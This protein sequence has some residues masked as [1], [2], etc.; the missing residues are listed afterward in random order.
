M[1]RGVVYLLLVL[2]V[3]LAV[4]WFAGPRVSMDATVTFDPATIGS[5]PDAYLAAAES[6]V[7]GIE[8]GLRKEI[9]WAHPA[10]K[11]R[12][13]LAIVYIHGFSA[14]K[15]ELRPLPDI[16]ARELGAN[17]FYTRLAGHGQDSAAM[18]TAS[19]K[20]WAD[21]FAEAMAIGRAIGERV[22][23]MATSTG[24]GLATWGAA[25]RP[26]LME[27]VEALVLF[28]P[29]FGAQAFGAGA[30]TMPWGGVLADWMTGG[31]RGFV[32]GNELQERWWTETYPTAATL[33]MAAITKLAATSPVEHI[34]I[35]TLFVISDGDRVV[36]PDITRRLAAR[37]GAP[38]EIFVVGNAE[39]RN[40]HIIAGDAYS[41]SAT[42]PTADKIVSW[43]SA[44]PR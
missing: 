21:D 44:L 11:A 2:V 12:T 10:S 27:N 35:P 32:T 42:Q 16:V 24:G 29:N 39:D 20:A 8:P 22:V 14:S 43:I 19:V 4:A 3:A 34:R 5:D 25:R 13:P 15:G 17:L 28:S 7:S 26:D 31:T 1:R 36:R 41:P 6:R 23:V 40:Q 33:P 18:A 37:W 9:V 38:H 30:L